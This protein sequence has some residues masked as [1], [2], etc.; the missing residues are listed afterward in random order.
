MAEV[1][2]T[3]MPV[4]VPHVA[5]PTIDLGA[6][7]DAPGGGRRRAGLEALVARFR[8]QGMRGAALILPP[9]EGEGEVTGEAPQ[10][11]LAWLD[12]FGAPPEL[13]AVWQA[14]AETVLFDLSL[15][16]QRHG[17]LAVRIA[18][19]AAELL[20]WAVGSEVALGVLVTGAGLLRGEAFRVRSEALAAWLSQ[21]SP[22]PPAWPVTPQEVLQH[23]A[24]VAQARLEGLVPALGLGAGAVLF[25]DAEDGC[26]W[27]LAALGLAPVVR[28]LGLGAGPAGAAPVD[29]LVAAALGPGRGPHGGPRVRVASDRATREAWAEAGEAVT[30]A[31]PWVIAAAALPPSLSPASRSLVVALEGRPVDPRWRGRPGE[32][33]ATVGMA[34]AR[35]AGEL[36]PALEQGLVAWRQQVV[37]EVLRLL[38]A[39]A[40]PGAVCRALATRCAARCV[41]WFSVGEDGLRVVGWSHAAAPPDEAWSTADEQGDPRDAAILHGPRWPLR[42]WL[43]A[44]GFA[45]W[46]PWVEALGVEP[47]SVGTLPIVRG[48]RVTGLLRV[49]GAMSLMAGLLRR[50]GA[51]RELVWHRPPCTPVHVRAALEEVARLLALV[52]DLGPS[53]T[54]AGW[55][56]ALRRAQAGEWGSEEDALLAELSRQAPTQEALGEL[57]GLHRNTVR[58]H[59]ALL[60]E[61]AGPDGVPWR[62]R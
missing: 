12:A 53:D 31:P 59:L 10:V 2:L 44:E 5:L 42:A 34:V 25:P 7:L 14:D 23:V 38:D 49:D 56:R 39:R 41:A 20:G 18:P 36:V 28:D 16:G 22:A 35:L 13:P 6:W 29:A 32:L 55:Q 62:L 40:S 47:E 30:G 61:A 1:R 50:S 27:P 4:G 48:G 11:D 26:A 52:G 57:L 15:H 33:T 24:E 54:R 51:R 43:P 46:G 45:T 19:E 9:E 8:P 21:G 37:T 60:V 17:V 58:R 3:A